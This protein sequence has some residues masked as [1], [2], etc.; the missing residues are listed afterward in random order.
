MNK[1]L[2]SLVFA[3]CTLLVGC[4]TNVITKHDVAT[5]ETSRYVSIPRGL[6]APCEVPKPPEVEPYMKLNMLE[7]ES[8]LVTYS[9]EL[10]KTIGTCNKKLNAI[11][12]W[13]EKTSNLYNNVKNDKDEQ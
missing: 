11:K 8:T 5:K 1:I 13:D 3:S 10:L 4:G 12:E 7:R 2:I 6:Y 9:S